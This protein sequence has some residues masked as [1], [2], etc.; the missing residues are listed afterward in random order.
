VMQMLMFARLILVC[1]KHLCL[2][3]TTAAESHGMFIC[4]SRRQTGLESCYGS[5]GTRQQDWSIPATFFSDALSCTHVALA[6]V[7]CMTLT[8][9]CMLQSQQ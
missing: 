8:S 9:S 1:C 6:G 4:N 2:D 3:C 5:F 7:A